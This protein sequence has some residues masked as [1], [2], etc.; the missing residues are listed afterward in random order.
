MSEGDETLWT[1][2]D[3]TPPLEI[4]RHTDSPR[5][6]RVDSAF[7]LSRISRA[8]RSSNHSRRISSLLYQSR[9]H[10]S[11]IFFYGAVLLSLVVLSSFVVLFF[12]REIKAV[13]VAGH[14]A[15][16]CGTDDCMLHASELRARMNAAAD[17]C[18]SLHA[19]VCGGGPRASQ[20]DEERRWT[21]MY[22]EVMAYD[23]QKYRTAGNCSH[24]ESRADTKAQTAYTACLKRTPSES[25]TQAA[26]FVDFMKERRIPW[27]N[28]PPEDVDLLDVLLDLVINWRVAL[29]FDLRRSTRKFHTASLVFQEPGPLI[30]LRRQ[31]VGHVYEN[32][33]DTEQLITRAA[34]FLGKSRGDITKEQIDALRRDEMTL[35]SN[36]AACSDERGNDVLVTLK[37]VQDMAPNMKPQ[38]WLTLLKRHLNDD[39]LTSET[40]VFAYDE[41][42]LEALSE[43]LTLLPP[44]RSLNVVGWLFAYAYIWVVNPDFDQLRPS[45]DNESNHTLNETL[46]FLAV[47][48]SF[49]QLQIL[50]NFIK[51]FEHGDIQMTSKVLQNT[52]DTFVQLV[53]NSDAITESAKA[54]AVAKIKSLCQERCAVRVSNRRT[55]DWLYRSFPNSSSSFFDAWLST[56]KALVALLKSG[57]PHPVMTARF[58]WRTQNIRYLHSIN[59][60]QVRM[61]AFYPPSFYIHGSPSM[62]Y[63]GLGFQM[64]SSI[65]NAVVGR[66]RSIDKGLSRSFWWS[67]LKSCRWDEASSVHDKRFIKELF[68]LKLAVKALESTA[69]GDKAFLQLQPLQTLTGRQTFYAS[70]CSRFCHRVDG[71]NWCNLAMHEDGYSRA[72]GCH[73]VWPR[74]M[75]VDPE[76]LVV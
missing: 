42:R 45:G 76:C 70:F 32:E 52:V 63:S 60:L 49:G 19:F 48:E 6:V 17:P 5:S 24:R 33:E 18:H 65:A 55:L 43:A 30:E 1:A 73:S 31:Q 20:R 51:R 44:A 53:Q 41:Q 28:D 40:T 27:P 23:S 13:M 34:T 9:K 21:R 10:S 75:K 37:H 68:A 7:R 22:G 59:F 74:Y 61:F 62:S 12:L 57:N 25:G 58:K 66:G 39:S 26:H 67:S 38:S 15:D 64:A 2:L 14:T 72:F 36:L 4:P 69:A 29:L 56:R 47:H 35:T 11:R 46:C 16:V 3:S 8:R 71:E 50:H 54:T